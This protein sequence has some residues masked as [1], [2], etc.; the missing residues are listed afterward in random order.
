VSLHAC[1][2]HVGRDIECAT[3]R[4]TRGFGEIADIAADA[5]PDMTRQRRDL[6]KRVRLD[7]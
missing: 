3:I 2:E 7:P 5:L 1:N 6:V 4:R